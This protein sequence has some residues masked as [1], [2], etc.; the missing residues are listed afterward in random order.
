[1][2]R[3]LF[4]TDNVKFNGETY[5]IIIVG[6][7]LAGLYCALCID[8]KYRVAIISKG[9]ISDGSSFLAQGGIAAVTKENDSFAKCKTASTP[10]RQKTNSRN[11]RRAVETF[12][13]NGTSLLQTYTGKQDKIDLSMIPQAHSCCQQVSTFFDFFC[14]NRQPLLL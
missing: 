11:L 6:S 8:E 12:G 5:D 1:M 14:C 10:Q 3:Y 13:P 7:G 9:D 4:S 2:R